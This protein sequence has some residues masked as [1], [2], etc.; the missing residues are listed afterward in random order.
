[1]TVALKIPYNGYPYP[2]NPFS[3]AVFLRQRWQL[4]WRQMPRVSNTSAVKPTADNGTSA[5]NPGGAVQ[6]VKTQVAL[7]H[8]HYVLHRSGYSYERLD[9]DDFLSSSWVPPEIHK[10]R[11]DCMVIWAAREGC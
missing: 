2:V 3:S 1:M 8:K 7:P 6:A 9:G 11:H 10:V 5:E 4:S